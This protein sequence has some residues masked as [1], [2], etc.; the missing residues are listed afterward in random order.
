MR[1]KRACL[2]GMIFSLFVFIIWPV[3]IAAAGVPRITKEALKGNL[4]NADVVVIDVRAGR[5]WESSQFKIKGA[6]RE[7][8]NDFNS[9]ANK[10]PKERTFVIYCA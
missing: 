3:N 6:V 8:G 5:D 10:Y 1:I 2:T 7:D 4:G 9:W